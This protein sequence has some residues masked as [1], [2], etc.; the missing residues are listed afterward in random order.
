MCNGES[1]S[2]ALFTTRFSNCNPFTVSHPENCSMPTN[3]NIPAVGAKI[4][5]AAQAV[6]HRLGYG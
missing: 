3:L 5:A 6:S 1:N 2:A 4:V